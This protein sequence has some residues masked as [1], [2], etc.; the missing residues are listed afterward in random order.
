LI[1]GTSS[2]THLRENLASASLKLPSD[3]VTV[4]DQ[5]AGGIAPPSRR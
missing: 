3:K 1:P 2:I 5:I 4:L